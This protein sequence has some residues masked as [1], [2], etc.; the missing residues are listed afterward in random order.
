MP[1]AKITPPRSETISGVPASAQAS[2]A[3]AIA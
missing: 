2:E 1:V 3:A